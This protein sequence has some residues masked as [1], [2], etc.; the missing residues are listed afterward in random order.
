MK[1]CVLLLAIADLCMAGT[2]QKTFIGVIHDNRC[3]GPDCARQCPVTKDPK[4]TLQSGG[5]AWVLS[6]QKS[7]ARYTGKKVA[8]TGTLGPRNTLV[9]SSITPA[10]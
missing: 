3:V 6:D 8:V 4:Y 2:V 10:K 5:E 7:V 9:V 1:R